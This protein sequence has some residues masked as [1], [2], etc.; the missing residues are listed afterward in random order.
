MSSGFP[1][2]DGGPDFYSGGG[3]NPTHMTNMNDPQVP[4]ASTLRGILS[5]P[6]SQIVHPPRTDLIG[7]RSY[8]EFQQQ[9]QNLHHQQLQQVALHNL[10]SVK[11]RVNYHHPSPISPLS[12]GDF[13]SVSS[14]SP[15]LSAPS[16]TASP[17]MTTRYGRPIFREN[18]F[19][20]ISLPNLGSVDQELVYLRN[21]SEQKMMCRLQELEKELLGDDENDNG[22]D[23]VSAVT[24]SEW[25]DTIQNLNLISGYQNPF[26]PSPTSSSSSCSS[27][28]DSPPITSPGQSICNVATAI[29]DGKTE[30]AA[31]ILN[32][33]LQFSNVKG[34]SEQRLIFYMA[35]AL[36]FRLNF[37]ENFSSISELYSKQH[38]IST[39][40]L[41][42]VSPCFKLG[43]MA[44]NLA[45]LESISKNINKI[46]V[47]DLDIGHGGQYVHLLHGLAAKKSKSPAVLKLSTFADFDDNGLKVL[48]NKIGVSFSFV[49]LNL[50]VTDLSRE[51]LN[52][53]DD[54]ALVVNFAY[55]LYQLPD[56]S[57]TTENQR[58]DLLRRVK[59]L[60]PEVMTVV[61]QE[62]NANTAPFVA[63]VN[64][65]WG[66]YGALFD[67][68][69]TDVSR[70][71][72]QRVRIEEGL[73]RNICNAVACEGMAR[74]ERCELFGK[75]RA[76]LSMAGF[77]PKPT[78]SLVADSLRSKLNSGTRGNPG[79]TVEEKSGS[80]SLGWKGRTLTVASAWH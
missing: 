40:M 23:V 69:D 33:L 39:Q 16:V 61:E 51:N 63:R 21:Q 19:S 17:H 49:K 12:P 14:L 44:A 27:T 60:S 45:I 26:S 46:H 73:G 70:T 28:L 7:K 36:R 25:F 35:S 48:A 65:L 66:Y 68:L 71:G 42:E 24:N 62:M 11:R 4:Y 6:S 64:E 5:D 76:R 75:W 77:K 54:E 31:E 53:L 29:A 15:E 32:R 52:V 20:P 13:S 47:L 72:L 18:N 55:K 57:V 50:K 74:V 10:R 67:S 59:G 3:I 79:F 22:V 8:P 80:V 58:D 34:T 78:S 2:G 41:H 9:Y 38:A 37:K 1:G 56:E 43:F 30:V